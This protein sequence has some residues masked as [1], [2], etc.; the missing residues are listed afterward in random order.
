M[1]DEVINAYH[2]IPGRDDRFHVEVA[3]EE[4]NDAIRNNLAIFHQ[5]SSEIPHNGG[6]VSHLEARANGN[7][8]TT[9]GYDLG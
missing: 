1:V 7:L 3:R 2:V 6:V 5:Y 8:I 9:T 4:G